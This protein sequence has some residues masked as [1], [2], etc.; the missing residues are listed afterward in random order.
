M[1]TRGQ[2]ARGRVSLDKVVVDAAGQ[3]LVDVHCH[4]LPGVD[5]GPA[6]LEEAVALCS[7]LA[8]EQVRTVIATPHQLGRWDGRNKPAE[9]RSQVSQLNQVLAERQIK[10]TILPGA[11]VRVDERIPWLLEKDQILTLADQGNFVLLELPYETFVDIG[12][13]MG[14]L[15]AKGVRTVLA[16]PERNVFLAANPRFLTKWLASRPI[17][18]I[19]AGSLIGDLGHA[20]QKAAWAI[21]DLD[22]EVIV[23]SD[24]HHAQS[25]PPRLA[26]AMRRLYARNP[27][28]SNRAFRLGPRQIIQTNGHRPP[29]G[30]PVTG[31]HP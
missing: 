21:L 13:F 19:N 20:V 1:D 11:E 24:A 10:L 12:P 26:E 15:L 25:R 5:D 2:Q 6:D 7:A 30:G 4:C 14:M 29:S 16:H 22:M 8:A 17:V 31:G 3:G 27:E 23:A 9:I 18:Q 28:L